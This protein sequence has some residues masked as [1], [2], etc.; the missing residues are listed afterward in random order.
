MAASF[1]AAAQRLVAEHGEMVD[2]LFFSRLYDTCDKAAVKAEIKHAGGASNWYASV[3]LQYRLTSVEG[4]H[5]ISL[6]DAAHHFHFENEKL[7]PMFVLLWR[8]NKRFGAA[9]WPQT[10][11]HFK[12]PFESLRPVGS[13][14]MGNLLWLL[15]AGGYV[16]EPGTL[17][18][19]FSRISEMLAAMPPRLVTL[20]REA[21]LPAPTAEAAPSAE[22]PVLSAEAAADATFDLALLLQQ[23]EASG[24]TLGK[25]KATWAE[26][27]ESEQVAARVL[28]F[29]AELWDEGLT[30]EISFQ[31]FHLLRAELRAAAE[32]LGYTEASWNAELSDVKGG[33]EEA[34]AARPAAA[35]WAEES[36]LT[37]DAQRLRAAFER[38]PAL[39]D[40]LARLVVRVESALK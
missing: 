28:G 4:V 36:P 21:E 19:N 6:A 30:P 12:A 5:K 3:G 14:G 40:D 13:K 10:R 22:S 16:Q 24:S 20:C 38:D 29:A 37:L 27:S 15:K 34:E 9:N 1:R 35:T 39:W 33:E 26:M 8:L 2:A 25:D 32:I 17:E 31:P 18:W 11:Q 7:E 23:P